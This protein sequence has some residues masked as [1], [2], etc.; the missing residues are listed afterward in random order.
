V[1]NGK[2]TNLQK[3]ESI[4]KII[5]IVVIA[6]A[7]VIF[8]NMYNDRS[9]EQEK[10]L[11]EQETA[12]A[13]IG[14]IRE[15]IPSLVS[16]DEEEKRA[17]LI[18]LDSMG[19]SEFVARFTMTDTSRGSKEAGD[20]LMARGG[21]LVRDAS[22]PPAVLPSRQPSKEVTGWVYLGHYD[23]RSRSWRTRYFDF[24]E[25]VE[26]DNLV[27]IPAIYVRRETGSVN[28]R[29]DMPDT[30][31]KLGDKVGVLNPGQKIKVLEVREWFNSGYL[32][33]KI[34]M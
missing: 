32:W 3:M 15:F 34:K 10:I 16:D 21:T 9:L 31:G 6:G 5:S 23:S 27:N 33:A 20:L 12:I 18:I 19:Q 13:T 1:T 30:Y 22:R 26:P 25:G 29:H 2:Q 4:A 24:K 8:T 11:R 17:A 14:M 7:G 28:V